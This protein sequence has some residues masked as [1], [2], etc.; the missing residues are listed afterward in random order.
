MPRPGKSGRRGK[1]QSRFFER[2][3]NPDDRR[4]VRIRLSEKGMQLF[5]LVNGQFLAMLEEFSVQVTPE[6]MAAL[7]C[8]VQQLEE[9]RRG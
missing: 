5:Q 2:H 9:S 6:G 4:A 7:G 3:E 8:M 1:R